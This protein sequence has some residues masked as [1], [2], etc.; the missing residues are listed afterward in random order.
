MVLGYLI[1]TSIETGLELGFWTMRKLLNG[2]YTMTYGNK[3]DEKH[4]LEEQQEHLK[5]L[6]NEIG[7]LKELIKHSNNLIKKTE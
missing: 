4:G 7:E 5:A 1:A 3:Q 6:R 2:I